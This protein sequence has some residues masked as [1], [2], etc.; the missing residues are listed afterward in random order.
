M[1]CNACGEQPENT[2]KDFTRAVIEINN[3]EEIVLFRKVVIPASM[4]DDTTVPPAIGKYYNV[5]LYYEANQKSY[6]YSSDGIPTQLVNGITDY[7]AAVNLPQIN[8]NT[9][10]G[11]K[12]GEELGLQD[13][14][15]AGDGLEVDADGTLSIS[16]IEQYAHFFDTVA[17]MKA[18]DNLVD[19]SFVETYGFYSKGDMGGVKYKIRAITNTDIVDERKIIALSNEN[20]IAELIEHD[21]MNARQFGLYCDNEHDDTAGLN[22]IIAN[23]NLNKINLPD[24]GEIKLDGTINLSRKI[25]I[26]LN[27][28]TIHAEDLASDEYL[29]NITTK[30]SMQPIIRNGV[31]I[32]NDV[33]NF[34]NAK[35]ASNAWGVSF[36]LD[37]LRVNKFVKLID[38]FAMFNCLI[39]NTTFLSDYGYFVISGD[40]NNMSNNNEFSHCYFKGLDLDTTHYPEY[41]MILTYVINMNF[42][43]CAFE[44][45]NKFYN[46]SNCQTIK[47][48]NCESEQQNYI[49]N[50]N[51]GLIIDG[52][53]KIW[54]ATKVY[55]N[56]TY[57]QR[58]RVE[59]IP[60]D[61]YTDSN[62]LSNVRKLARTAT[63]N[64]TS[65]NAVTAD[66]AHFVRLYEISP[67]YLNTWVPVNLIEKRSD[68]NTAT[69][70]S[71]PL[72]NIFNDQNNE[73]TLMTI[74]TICHSSD[75][76][77]KMV[78]DVWLFRNGTSNIVKATQ[79]NV[80]TQTW[81]T[82]STNTIT[83]DFSGTT[84]SV[85]TTGAGYINVKV[86]FEKLGDNIA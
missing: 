53:N 4:G 25:E 78:K 3:P 31:I 38:A 42:T 23:T 10:I 60:Q 51:K 26:D 76:S 28:A 43:S 39:S 33:A 6:L 61:I 73:S 63:T 55:E 17:D 21:S 71:V 56:F 64:I 34:I 32:G 85:A 47:W 15:T 66:E 48:Y 79:E 72:Y 27:K 24:S 84:L 16:D 13:K 37:E 9:L 77:V 80:F 68:D 70:L 74:Y 8:G 5:L 65:M 50:T 36:K 67:A 35:L 12:T 44:Q 46:L 19:G 62:T 7:E 69:S 45:Y 1:I 57:D 22:Y 81:G 40:S 14:L 49:A 58:P 20:L 29:F 82:Q 18:A 83:L 75:G 11:D 52:S 2:A 41:R 30:F 86:K 54:N 59:F